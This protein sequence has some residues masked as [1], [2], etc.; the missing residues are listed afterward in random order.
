MKSG[1]IIAGRYEIVRALGAGGM[2]SVYQ[3][4][5]ISM[6]RMVA[7]KLIH[8]HIASSSDVAKRFHREMQ[9]TSKIEHAN[10]IRVFDY[11]QAEDGQLFLA[12]EFL[13]GKPLGK[14]LEA[15]GPLP[16]VR[17]V[18]IAAQIARALAAAHE[19]GIAHRD[20]KPDNVMLLDRYGEK[21]F[22]KVLDFGIARFVDTPPQTQMTTDG[23]VI[24]TPAYMSP[25]Q[26]MG[27]VVDKRADFYSLGVM[28]FQMATGRLPFEG[29]TLAA[30]LVAHATEKPPLPSSI[31]PVPPR[32]E[33]LILRLMA[34]SPDE[35]PRDAAEVLREIE[36]CAPTGSPLVT[37]QPMEAA[38]ASESPPPSPSPRGSRAPLLIA[39]AVVLLGGGLVAAKL[40]TSKRHADDAS[41]SA[42]ARLEALMIADGDPLPPV[43][44]RA[45]DPVLIDRLARAAALLQGSTVG[46]ARP[47][48]RDALTALESGADGAASTEYWSLLSRA[49]L[50]VENS[51]GALEAANKAV[52]RCAGSALAHNLVGN[53]QQKARNFDA[54][55]AS[56]EKAIAIA[57]DYLAPRFNLGLLALRANDAAGAVAAFDAV[58][59]K[60]PLHGSAHL[61]RGRAHLM[62]GDVQAALDDLEQATL[63]HPEQADAWLLLGQARAKAGSPKTANEA[64]CKAKQLGSDDAAKLCH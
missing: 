4:R 10:T 11:G 57:P 25:E 54:A 19:E 36:K 37:T 62:R 35:R 47:Q 6:D 59:E 40:A 51:D 61:A 34:K 1:T 30:L 60:D 14:I 17:I 20:L 49:R 28:L 43:D 13:D 27:H 7:L 29:P 26:A 5:Q 64:W 8:P 45:K 48:D 22:V 18:H 32:L 31:R 38:K 63:R 12:M 2:G 44:C 56:Y 50:V 46:K 24:G 23:A 53:A 9:A 16:L 58:L 42:R 41:T 55:K 52:D 33:A 3:A 39:G 21:D 15:T